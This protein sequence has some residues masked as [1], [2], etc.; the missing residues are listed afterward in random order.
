MKYDVTFLASDIVAVA[1]E[2]RPG[3]AVQVV[4]QDQSYER[5]FVALVERVRAMNDCE[6]LRL[7][8]EGAACKSDDGVNVLVKAE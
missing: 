2:M 5:Y 6:R 1:K 3:Y 7:L 8:V 4:M